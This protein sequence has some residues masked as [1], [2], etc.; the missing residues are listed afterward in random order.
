MPG[1]TTIVSRFDANTVGSAVTCPPV[2]SFCMLAPSADANTSAGAPPWIWV[3]SVPDDP[4]LNVTVVPGLRFWKS[5]PI[6]VNASVVDAA[7]DT[8]MVPVT[9]GVVVVVVFAFAA[10][11]A[12]AMPVPATNPRPA[13]TIATSQNLI[14]L[15]TAAPVS[16]PISGGRGTSTTTFVDF[17]TATARSPGSMP[18]SS[19]ASRV[20]SDVTLCGPAWMCT[21]A[22]RPSFCTW[23]TM[24]GNRLRADSRTG[25]SSLA[26]A[27]SVRKRASSA[28]SMSRSPPFGREPNLPSSTQRR[29]VSALTPSSSAT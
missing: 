22:T 18:R 23:V 26:G 10:F 1:F 13:I 2:T 17:T 3:A 24:P 14:P 9:F 6:F 28:P 4:K 20:I 5:A 7:A 25:G 12:C 8:V 11:A 16:Q 19:A 15:L 29:T 21:T 27:V